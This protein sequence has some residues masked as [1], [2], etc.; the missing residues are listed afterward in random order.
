MELKDYQVKV[1]DSLSIYLEQLKRQIEAKS[2]FYQF[3][4]VQGREA[5]LPEE[6][7]YCNL[8]WDETK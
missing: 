3:Q 1:I 2:E 4:I 5:A 7:D 8:A 6:S